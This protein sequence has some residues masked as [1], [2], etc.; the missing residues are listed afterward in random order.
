M[1][2]LATPQQKNFG[3]DMQVL[4]LFSGIG[5]FSI[6]LERVGMTTAAFC[7]IDEFPRKVLKKHWPGVPIYEDVTKL[8]KKVLDDDGIT[9]DVICGGFPCQDL[10]VAGK[11]KGSEA[12]RSGL[13][14]EF[15]R[16]ISEIRPRSA[17]VE[18]VTAL[19]SGD[20]GGWFG[21][22]L[23]DLAE[24]GYD[25]EWHCI[26]A[27]D[28]GAP[29]KRDRV[30]IVAYP[31]SDDRGSGR[32]TESFERQAWV[33][34]G[35]VS[36]GQYERESKQ[37]VA[38]TNGKRG[39]SGNA[40]R[41]DAKN[42]WQQPR[43]KIGLGRKFDTWNSE[44]TVGRVANGVSSRTHRLKCLGNAVVPQIPEILGRAILNE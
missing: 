9:I 31:N 2:W 37:D 35:S 19:L 38:Y 44:P 23:G 27:S 32:S 11:Q 41:K 1:R 39:C 36:P 21:R 10:C 18:N 24:I 12:K 30:W 4:D 13:W 26:R 6:G 3:I 43:C 42:A 33:E 34:S 14:G 40:Q 16:L 5:G 29:H 7:E 28:I 17:I 22:V 15:S 8:S 25:A 20:R